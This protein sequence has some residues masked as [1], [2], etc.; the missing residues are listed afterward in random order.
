MYLLLDKNEIT[1]MGNSEHT[2]D[3]LEFIF[4]FAS[5]IDNQ[6]SSCGVRH[7]CVCMCVFGMLCEDQVI[8]LTGHPIASWAHPVAYN[9]PLSLSSWACA[10]FDFAY[11]VG[12]TFQPKCLNSFQIV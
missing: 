12:Q 6:Q 8:A 2:K 3:E 7:C 10:I 11:K 5:S 9:I 1:K 4:L